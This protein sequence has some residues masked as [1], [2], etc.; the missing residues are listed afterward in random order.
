MTNNLSLTE[1]S[2]A[3]RRACAKLFHKVYNA[4]PFEYGWLDSVKADMY[5][6]DLESMPNALS[7]ILTDGENIVGACMGQK[8]AHFE[9]PLYRINEFFIEPERQHMGLGTFFINELEGKLKQMGLKSMNLFTQRNMG[10]YAFY[11]KNDFIPSD[12]TVHMA[13]AIRQEPTVLYARTF[14]NGEEPD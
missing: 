2:P 13:R 4:P 7:Y 12:E 3:H 5:F 6:L 10:S 14:I 1:Y 8:E 11:R 9:N